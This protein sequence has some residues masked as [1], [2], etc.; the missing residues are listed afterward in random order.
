MCVCMHVVFVQPDDWQ[1]PER[2]SICPAS[3]FLHSPPRPGQHGPPSSDAS[4]Q[5]SV[6]HTDMYSLAQSQDSWL[7]QFFS[8]G[9]GT[10][11]RM[12]LWWDQ[13]VRLYGSECDDSLQ[14]WQRNT[15]PSFICAR[16]RA[17]SAGTEVWWGSQTTC[18][19]TV[20]PD[21]GAQLSNT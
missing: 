8:Q 11:C 20:R 7:T 9:R 4:P 1:Y 6:K 17:E 12:S 19:F 2:L 14:A 5:H 15:V 10:H 18:R 16:N 21:T 3:L 13:R